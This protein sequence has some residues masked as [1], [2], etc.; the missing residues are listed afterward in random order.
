METLKTN[1]ISTTFMLL[2]VGIFI[3]GLVGY[4]I[5]DSKEFFMAILDSDGF[6]ALG[7]TLLF[8]PLVVTLLF[9]IVMNKL[10]II[11]SY[12]LFV[13]FCILD[14]LLLGIMFV[15]YTKSSILLTF[16]IVSITFIVM[17]IIGYTTKRDLSK[18]S[19]VLTMALIGLVITMIL[20]WMIGSETIS[21]I[22]SGIAVIVYSGLI[23]VETKELKDLEAT[24]TDIDSFR[25]NSII[26][27]L[28]LHM[29]FISLFLHLLRFLG[30]K[31]I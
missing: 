5:S 1:L 18:L 23:V 24:T 4:S 29:S 7:W 11:M 19:S 10:N 16:G 20:N 25:K 8:S 21:Y 30:D 22:T 17:S 15:I 12:V 6:N 2:S 26:G 14:G 13:V 3:T 9:P 27:A 28:S 31:K